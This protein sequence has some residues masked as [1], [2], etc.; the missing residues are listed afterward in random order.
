M[1]I[2]ESLCYYDI[3]N[4]NNNLDLLD[5]DDIPT[6]KDCY[7]DNCFYGRTKL[8]EK[9]LELEKYKKGFELLYPY[10][11]SISDEEQI[12]VGKKLN[13]LKL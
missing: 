12:K 8:A 1:N 9:I 13:K 10:F 7:C 6:K 11:D 3:K 4:P 2:L 5:K